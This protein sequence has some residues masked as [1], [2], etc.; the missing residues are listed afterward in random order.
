MQQGTAVRAIWLPALLA[1]ALAACTGQRDAATAADSAA[2]AVPAAAASEQASASAPT[3]TA[4]D[5]QTA[6]AKDG[7]Q[8]FADIRA[9]KERLPGKPVYVAHCAMCH[10]GAVAKAPH[11]DMIGMMTPSAVVSALTT[12]IMSAQG[13]ALTPTDRAQVAEYLTGTSLS[14]GGPPPLPSCAA[15]ASPFNYNR[16]TKAAGWGQDAANSHQISAYTAGITRADVPHL[17][18]KWAVAFPGAN[19]S[20][21]QPTFA[22]G[23][24]YVGSHSGAVYAFDANTGCVRW[25]FAASGEVRSGIVIERWKAGDQKAKPRAYFGDILGNVYAID[26]V[27]GSLIWRHRPDDHP[28]ATISGS[29][30]LYAGKLYV[31]VSSLEVAL[32]VDPKY[33]CCKARGWVAAYNAAT[34]ALLWKTPSIA[35]TPVVQ[36][37]NRSGTDMYGPSGATI[38][39]TPTIDPARK[40]LYVGTGENMS[41]PATLTSDAIMAMDLNTGT[42][43]WSYQATANDVWNA[44]CD[45][46]NDDS[47]PPEKG[48]DFDFGAGTLL[49][50]AADGTQ[51]VVGGQKSGDVHALSPDT[52]ALVWKTKVGRG[53]IQGGVHFGIAANSEAVFVPITDMSDGRV[54]NSPDRPGMHAVD[55]L[56][57]KPLWYSP[58]PIVCAGRA[59]CHPG[60][61]QSISVIGDVVVAGAMD[62]V[63]RIHAVE[64]GNLLW[65]YDSTTEHTT[66]NGTVARGGSMGGGAAPVAEN[67][68]LVLSSGY[69]I[70]NHMPGNLLLVFEA[71]H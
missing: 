69:G 16:P 27:S 2:A 47:C 35:A 6:K 26:A 19:R 57:G 59:F 33:E 12:G 48:P 7:A 63:A 30:A 50:T 60:N 49:F 70:Y 14:D 66:V 9:A 67:G 4:A 45:T 64:S 38:W 44:A 8:I 18:L 22:G 51:L 52:G 36:S 39:N 40:Q 23:A 58:S 10:D 42:V 13:S 25:S 31:P 29:P 1:F 24:I 37:Q 3:D 15:G 62:G 53:G 32:A 61:S 68:L 21:S 71:A 5:A 34:G 65:Q 55:G 17:K 28:N 11:R 54:Y 41:S 56:T 46:A 43:K 20:R